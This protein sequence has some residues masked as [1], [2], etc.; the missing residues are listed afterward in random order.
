M[1]YNNMVYYYLNFCWLCLSSELGKS[2]KIA[3]ESENDK[4]NQDILEVVTYTLNLYQLY[5]R[6]FHCFW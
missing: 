1:G 6:S 5:V 2:I 4:K 3:P